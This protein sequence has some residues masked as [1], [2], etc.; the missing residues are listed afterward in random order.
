MSTLEA[1]GRSC[2]GLRVAA[3]T[4]SSCSGPTSVT[5][6]PLF[7]GDDLGGLRAS[8]V[9]NRKPLAVATNRTGEESLTRGVWEP[10][11]EQGGHP[12]GATNVLALHPGF[13]LF[14]PAVTLAAADP[15]PQPAA[16]GCGVEAQAGRLEAAG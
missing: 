16:C 10:G 11:G 8:R 3:L 13:R 5:T 2:S 14:H 9:S 1:P 6:P 12:V 4:C 7:S 15:F